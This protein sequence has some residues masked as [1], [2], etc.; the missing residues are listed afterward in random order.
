MTLHGKSGQDIHQK[1][2]FCA[3]QNKVKSMRDTEVIFAALYLSENMDKMLK[4]FYENTDVIG[5][6]T[7]I[8][9]KQ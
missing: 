2:M 3:P 4:P 6:S 9:S 8:L 7:E 5:A 1:W